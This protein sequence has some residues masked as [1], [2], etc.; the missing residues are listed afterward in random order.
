MSRPAA[1]KK[2]VTRGFDIHEVSSGKDAN[3]TNHSGGLDAE[4]VVGIRLSAEAG[5]D[6]RSGMDE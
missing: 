4:Q 5:R 2:L 1:S 3:S 6:R